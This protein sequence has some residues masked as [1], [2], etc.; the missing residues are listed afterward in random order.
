ME[1]NTIRVTKAQK[2][3]AIKA[4]IPAD[5]Q[6]T[7]PGTI[8]SNGNVI[9]A[10]YIFNHDEA[11]AFID[12]EL[13]MIAKKN[14][15]DKKLTK[16]QEANEGYKDKILDYLSKLPT[17]GEG[18]DGVTCTQMFKEIPEFAEYSPQKVSAL[19]RQLKMA[20]LITSKEVKGKTLFRLA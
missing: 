15:G 13:G 2:L 20:G 4:I 3:E 9:K 8:D 14:S 18:S 11:V 1:N 6:H 16:D 19:C 17:E 10:P 7:F 12:K 5:F